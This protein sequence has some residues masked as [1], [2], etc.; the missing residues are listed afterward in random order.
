MKGIVKYKIIGLYVG[1][2][3]FISLSC[4]PLKKVSY[5]N[6]IDEIEYPV[7]NPREQ[8]KIAPFDKLYIKVLSTDLETANILNLSEASPTE[9]VGYLVDENGN[10]DFPFAGV[11]NVGGLTLSQSVLVVKNALTGII[12]N[13]SVII[14]FI[15]KQITIMG[16]VQNQGVY[17]ITQDKITIYE[18]LALGG[19]L[20]RY[21]NRKNVIL[22]RHENNKTIH[23]KLDLS[24]SKI[25]SSELYYVLPNDII[26][27]EPNKSISWSSQSTAYTTILTTI[28]S[29]VSIFTILYFSNTPK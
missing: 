18:A 3:I 1:L 19:G 10:I 13:P 21:S 6:D 16:E 17:P 14:K 8:K 2:L 5:F 11:I 12:A 15:D 26:I 29:L 28:T 27:V 24:N 22:I 23:Y 4:I 9:T 7:A 20:T 25:A